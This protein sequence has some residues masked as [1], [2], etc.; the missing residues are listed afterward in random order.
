MAAHGAEQRLAKK[1]DQAATHYARSNHVSQIGNNNAQHN[2]FYP[3]SVADPIAPP[4]GG[5]LPS[6]PHGYVTRDRIIDEVRTAIEDARAKTTSTSAVAL[7]GMGGAGKSTLAAAIARDCKPAFANDVYWLKAEQ[8]MTAVDLQQQFAKQLGS[9]ELF[10]STEEGKH[11]LARLL[12]ARAVLLVVDNVWSIDTI[13]ALGVVR[14]HGVLLFTT[15]DRGIAQAIGAAEHEVAELGLDEALALLDKRAGLGNRRRPPVADELCRWVGQLAFGVALIGGMI[16][17]RGGHI[18]DWQGVWDVLRSTDVQAIAN[19]VNPDEYDHSNVLAC[20]ALSIDELPDDD[21]NRYQELAVFRDRGLVPRS[22]INALWASSDIGAADA[23]LLLTRL[24]NRCLVQREG[25][26]ASDDVSFTLHDLEFKVVHHELTKARDVESAH[27]RLIGGYYSW[28]QRDERVEVTGGAL[29]KQWAAGPNDGYLLQNLAFHLTNANHFELLSELLTSYAWMTRKLTDTDIALLL[30]DYSHQKPLLAP[31][32]IVHEVLQLSSHVLATEPGLLPGQLI[33]RL[34]GDE[35]PGLRALVDSARPPNGQWWMRPRTP[36]SLTQHGGPL[37]RR[38]PGQ[39]SPAKA[40]TFTPDGRFIVS[41]DGNTVRVW[42]AATG[43]FIDTIDH[44]RQHV[45]ALAATSDGHQIVSGSLDGTV[46][47]SALATGRQETV[48][49]VSEQV[50]AVA[51]TPDSKYVVVGCSDRNVQVWNVADQRMEYDLPGHNGRVTAVAVSSDGRIIVSGSYDKTVR[52]WST[53]SRSGRELG[54]DKREIEAVAISADG[55]YV[56]SCSRDRTM[57]WD[58]HGGATSEL[59]LPGRGVH[60]VAI[61]ADGAHIVTAGRDKIVRVWDRQSL[62]VREMPGHTDSVQAVAI[63]PSEQHIVSGDRDNSVC[64]W[65]F[66]QDQR[67][68][69]STLD[70]SREIEMIAFTGDG[71]RAHF[72]GRG[73]TFSVWD[74]QSAGIDHPLHEQLGDS[75]ATVVGSTERHLILGG[76]DGKVQVWDLVEKRLIPTTDAHTQRITAVHPTADG[77]HFVTASSDRTVKVWGLPGGQLERTLTAH[78]HEVYAVVV[79]PDSRQII[80]AGFDRFVLVS[81]LDS[82]RELCLLHGPDEEVTTLA[83]TSDGRFIVAGGK[84][85]RVWVWDREEPK[86][87]RPLVGHTDRIRTVAVTADNRY[88]LSG[89]DDRTLRL[90]SIATGSELARWITDTAAITACATHPSDSST[91]AYG[92]RSGRLAILSL[93]GPTPSHD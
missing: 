76:S 7:V 34:L 56:V 54:W 79:T 69:T 25:T 23:D 64:V 83:V 8:G 71:H 90:W 2:H 67:P 63:S 40:V 42:E 78:R 59:E 18:R 36:G 55:R 27:R 46:R 14:D 32:A 43:R 61:S 28:I 33:G 1:P 92:D 89:G 37:E 11:H 50:F 19:E 4:T 88:I 81:D 30:T 35:D 39:G 65:R 77:R 5:Y 62:R 49:P 58:T 9:A 12:G 10:S 75:A 52:V 44:H 51:V 31:V 60:S 91:V 29:A 15:R 26:D 66:S 20:I 3:P 74:W 68:G 82:G 24:V 85:H 41:G 70:H 84:D 86:T 47:V 73:S 16:T 57:V 45:T 93:H 6:N 38:L 17:A 87:P 80:S 21:R 48:L 22:A 13:P 72:S 53:D